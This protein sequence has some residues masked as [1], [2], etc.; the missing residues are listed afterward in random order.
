MATPGAR[1]SLFA[2]DASLCINGKDAIGAVFAVAVVPDGLDGEGEAFVGLA[3]AG[4]GAGNHVLVVNMQ[5]NFVDSL[6]ML[7]AL[8]DLLLQG[9]N[10]LGLLFLDGLFDDLGAEIN[11]HQLT[12]ISSLSVHARAEDRE[13]EAAG[14]FLANVGLAQV[15][16]GVKGG[17]DHFLANGVLKVILDAG[18]EGEG[19]GLNCSDGHLLE[20]CGVSP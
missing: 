6:T 18:R 13:L 12:T 10:C 8:I 17:E 7:E 9:G 2:V 19:L 15:V 1:S 3:Y 5:L 14:Q 11:R 20:A 16:A 4:D